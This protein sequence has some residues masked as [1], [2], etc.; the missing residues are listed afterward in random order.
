MNISYIISIFP[1]TKPILP[2]TMKNVLFFLLAIGLSLSLFAQEKIDI[3]SLSGRY[4]MPKEYKDAAYTGKATE[5][6]SLNSIT[7]R[8]GAG[9]PPP[10]WGGGNRGTAC[11]SPRWDQ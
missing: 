6:G 7:Q 8:G 10:P 1:G 9:S 3:L 5:W 2:T 4:G 11:R